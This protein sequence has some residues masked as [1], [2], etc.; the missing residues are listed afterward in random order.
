MKEKITEAYDFVL[1]DDNKLDNLI[2]ETLVRNSGL[3]SSVLVFNSAKSAL[4]Y[5][6]RIPV[7]SSKIILLDQHMPEMEGTE[8]LSNLQKELQEHFQM[9]TV[10]ILTNDATYVKK[11][12][13]FPFVKDV[14]SKPLELSKLEQLTQHH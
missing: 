1:I 7:H 4:E 2:N 14:W 8:F 10:V 6:Q 3:G 13:N 11:R 5:F 12:G 9:Y